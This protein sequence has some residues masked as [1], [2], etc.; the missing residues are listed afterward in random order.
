MRL[1]L[2]SDVQELN[3]SDIQ[4]TCVV[5][6]VLNTTLSVTGRVEVNFKQDI[7]INISIMH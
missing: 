3:F 4:Q 6:P 5:V 7:V 2:A 1:I